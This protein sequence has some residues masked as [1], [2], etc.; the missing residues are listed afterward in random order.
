MIRSALFLCASVLMA[1]CS[2]CAPA[3]KADRFDRVVCNSPASGSMFIKNLY[4]LPTGYTPY[5]GLA[6]PDPNGNATLVNEDPYLSSLCLAYNAAPSKFKAQLDGLKATYIDKTCTAGARCSSTS[7]GFRPPGTQD[8]YIAL[9]A[10]LWD[11]D[12]P[13]YSQFEYLVCSNLLGTTCPIPAGGTA[14]NP[15]IQPNADTQTMTIVA[16]LAHELG[17]LTWV[18]G[19]MEF[20]SC[21][22]QGKFSDISWN[23]TDLL[24]RYHQFGIQSGNTPKAGKQKND[25][26]TDIASGV[27]NTI[28]KDLDQI[29]KDDNWASL[30]ATVDMDEDFVETYKLRVLTTLTSN[31]LKAL[32][33]TVPQYGPH[34]IVDAMQNGNKDLHK[35]SQWITTCFPSL[36]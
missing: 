14:P 21:P 1:V 13:T 24:Q 33:V 23:K 3:N 11:G 31:P 26:I 30:F 4:Y 9:S 6:T 15:G 20:Y 32:V 34:D 7:W 25:I 12:V 18:V 22:G 36:P 35:K 10:G 29:Y 2:A 8:T 28:D 27:Q 5:P 17:H 16:V 19:N